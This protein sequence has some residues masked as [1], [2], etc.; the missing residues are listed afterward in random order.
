MVSVSYIARACCTLNGLVLS[1]SSA[2]DGTGA[3][4]DITIPTSKV[5]AK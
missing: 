4:F 1:V 3:R 5:R 2:G